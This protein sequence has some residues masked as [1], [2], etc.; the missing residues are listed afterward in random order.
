MAD[1]YRN[2]HYVPKWYQKRFISSNQTD[3]ELLYLN[4]NPPE[5]IDSKGVSHT[6][7]PIR[8]LGYTHCFSER[9][10][11]TSIFGEEMSTKI[12]E[13]FF[14]QIDTQGKRAVDYFTSFQHPSVDG[15]AFNNLMIYMS[16]QK[17]RTPKGLEWLSTFAKTKDKNDILNLML[18]LRQLFCAVW[19]E[20][21]WLI[22]DCSKSDT[23][24]II[25]DHPV[26][27][28]NRGCHP[29]S[30]WCN[31]INDP[32]VRFHGTHTIFPLTQEKILILTNL[33][34]ARNPYQSEIGVR[35]NPSLLRP[36]MFNFTDIQ[37][38]RFLSEQEVREINFIIKK[39]AHSFIGAAK[40]EWLYPEK[41]VSLSN[42]ESFG[43]GYLL[44]PDP[45]AVNAGGE[46]YW[47]NYDGSGGAI[48]A[49]GR[50]GGNPDFGK[51]NKDRTEFENLY[52]FKGEF[53][54]LYG[55]KRRGRS[56][57]MCQLDSEEDS[58]EYHKY[59]L[60]LYKKDGQ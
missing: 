35:P 43:N 52:K 21:V 10:L 24:F 38:L 39:R 31:G 26:T 56:F 47:G 55:P 11:Y 23:K 37:T 8:R 46:I 30:N 29:N 57:N 25:S 49:Y 41:Y 44:M 7:N 1:S 48:D 53:A 33:S 60:S 17:L 15:N 27:V 2:N 3:Q 58:V 51:E 20:C 59:H 4:L 16:T 13:L 42:W 5:V 18:Q 36:A 34:W 50:L 32:D 6:L 22:A 28:Y 9:D 12:E 14:G 45:R 40:E 54:H 19:T